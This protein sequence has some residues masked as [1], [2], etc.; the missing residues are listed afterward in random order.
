[1]RRF[2]FPFVLLAAVACSLAQQRL[3]QVTLSAGS[4]VHVTG[5]TSG[6]VLSPG[7][8]TGRPLPHNF[9][10]AATIQA[11]KGFSRI[12][13]EF[14][15]F[16]LETSVQCNSDKLI[17]QENNTSPKTF[18]SNQRPKAYL[19]K[20]STVSLILATDGLKKS[21]GF[22]V[23]FTATN[24]RD[25]C[26]NPNQYQCGSSECIP[27]AQV[28][29][30]R[31]DCADGTD[32]QYCQAKLWR[33]SLVTDVPCGSPVVRPATDAG[34]RIMG[35][36][37]AVPHS[38]PWQPSI[39][40]SGIFPAAHFC[41]GALLRNDLLI[42]AAHCI[43][44]M[45]PEYLVVKFGSHNLVGEEAGVQIRSV[46]VIARHSRF[47]WS[48]MTHDVAVLKLT[49]PV[50]FTDHVR[51]VCLPR[52]GVS[53]PLNTTCYTTGWGTTRGTGSSFLLKQARLT[54]RDFN[55]SCR[56][57][58]SLQPNLRPSHLVCA[59]DDVDSSGPCHGDS[60]GPL[61]CQLGSS[62]EW[63]LVGMTSQ[64]AHLTV[65]HALCAMGTGT[66]WSGVIPNR[67][68]IDNAMRTL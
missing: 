14:E 62:P 11:P 54:V 25:I 65:T 68:W 28:C 27:R 18:C 61:V 59:T 34:D 50:N 13:L 56:T 29:N 6:F 20:S 5:R 24:S 33:R 52:P 64:G 57:I 8:A 4:D 55:Q 48:D 22:R 41:G 7:F 35:G 45:R 40:L 32:E 47:T 1:M 46:D 21:R 3:V 2:I 67:P 31:F 16:D 36:R 60:G 58:L 63:N 44:G 49:L 23:R 38:W 39:Q 17:V 51:P 37:E 26:G 9:R 42:T 66:V 12:R 53:L 15:E 10:G 43:R 19:S 30:G